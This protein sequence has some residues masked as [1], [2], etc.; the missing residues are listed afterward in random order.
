MCSPFSKP[1]YAVYMD[2]I[3]PNPAFAMSSTHTQL[4]YSVQAGKGC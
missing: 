3:A 2:C 1:I 4:H